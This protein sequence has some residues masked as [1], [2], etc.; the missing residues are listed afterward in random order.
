MTEPVPRHPDPLTTAR[1]L[2][3]QLATT[4]HARDLTA[5]T[6]LNDQRPTPSS[7]RDDHGANLD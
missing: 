1:R 3:G 7:T 2:A 6:P 5:G 4:A